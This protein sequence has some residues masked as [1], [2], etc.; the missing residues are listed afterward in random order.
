MVPKNRCDHS[1]LFLATFQPFST[2]AKATWFITEECK[3][4][5][6]TYKRYT[7]NWILTLSSFSVNLLL[8]RMDL[9]KNQNGCIAPPQLRHWLASAKMQGKDT[10]NFKFRAKFLV[11]MIS[12]AGFKDGHV[13]LAAPDPSKSYWKTSFTKL[14]Q[15]W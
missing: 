12:L 14:Y 3:K 5:Q 2:Q 1:I 10:N 9:W 6:T 13:I 8:Y 15:K 4:L 11:S 7:K